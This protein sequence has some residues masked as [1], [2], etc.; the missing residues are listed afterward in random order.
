MEYQN[1]VTMNHADVL[2]EKQRLMELLKIPI[3]NLVFSRFYCELFL[4]QQSIGFLSISQSST[5]IQYDTSKAA[6][7]KLNWQ[8]IYSL[9]QSEL[10]DSIGK[11][12]RIASFN[13]LPASFRRLYIE[14]G[15]N[16]LI[17]SF[18]CVYENFSWS[19]IDEQILASA[20]VKMV[21]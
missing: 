19:T 2:R 11:Q 9:H 13:T 18:E 16:Q 10:N 15:E 5:G 14:D 21:S 20:E 3:S 4:N 12:I 1:I 8:K 17:A 6:L 7:Q